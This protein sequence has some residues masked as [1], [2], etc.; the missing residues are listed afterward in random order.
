MGSIYIWKCL[1]GKR[2]VV[3]QYSAEMSCREA[4][5]E[6]AECGGQTEIEKKLAGKEKLP[7]PDV[8]KW[9]N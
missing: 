7:V 1:K 9:R 3:Y 6:T 5:L 2:T 4:V 8:M